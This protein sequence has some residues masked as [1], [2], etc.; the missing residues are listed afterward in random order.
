MAQNDQRD[1]AVI[2]SHICWGPGHS[3]PP[4]PG[5]PQNPP[6]NS[7]PSLNVAPKREGV[8]VWTGPVAPH[9]HF[10]LPFSTVSVAGASLCNSHFPLPF[11]CQ[12]LHIDSLG[13]VEISQKVSELM[14]THI[15]HTTLFN[16]PS[17]DAL[18]AHLW[19][20]V[21][22]NKAAT[23]PALPTPVAALAPTRPDVQA[24]IT[25][26]AARF[27]GGADS[28]ERFWQVLVQCPEV[29]RSL[30]TRID[31]QH[32]Y[33]PKIPSHGKM[34][35]TQAALVEDLEA[36]D[37]EFFGISPS[38]ASFMDPQQRLLLEETWH[39]LEHAG[40]PPSSLSGSA[41]SVLVGVSVSEYHLVHSDASSPTAVSG[42][43]LNMTAGRVAYHFNL[44]GATSAI[45]TAC[46]SSLFALHMAAQQL[47]HQGPMA[48]VAG[49]NAILSPQVF[50]RLCS[51]RA[52]SPRGICAAFDASAD[53]YGRC[54]GCAVLVLEAAAAAAEAARAPL[55]VVRGG[56]VVSDG[57]SNGVSAPNGLAQRRVMQEA[58]G[59]AELAK[60]DV[61][62][63]EAH[64]TG[65]PLGDP[66][67]L[68]AVAAAYGRGRAGAPLVIGT[69]KS[70]LGHAESAVGAAAVMKVVLSLTHSFVPRLKHFQAL[71]PKA[72]GLEAAH[73]RLPLGDGL[74]WP[75]EQAMRRA[76][77]SSF[78]FSGTNVHMLFEE[79]GAEGG[80]AALPPAPPSALDGAWPLCLS[81]ATPAALAQ[82]VQRYAVL[83]P[84]L[85]AAQLPALC[86]AAL[87]C[88]QSHA[89]RAVVEAAD[90]EAMAVQ[91]RAVGQ[92]GAFHRGPGDAEWGLVLGAGVDL[93]RAAAGRA[94]A[95]PAFRTALA[96]CGAALA[97]ATGLDLHRVL[98]GPE[99][100]LPPAHRLLAGLALEY[101]YAALLLAHGARPHVLLAYGAGQYVAGA[102]AGALPLPAALQLAAAH[103]GAMHAGPAPAVGLVPAEENVAGGGTGL[104]VYPAAQGQRVA[105]GTALPPG[106]VPLPPAEA[107]PYLPIASAALRA[108]MEAVAVR[109]PGP[110]PPPHI[111]IVLCGPGHVLSSAEPPPGP[112]H[113]AAGPSQALDVPAAAGALARTGALVYA[114]GAAVPPYLRAVPEAKA[115]HVG[116]DE[117]PMRGLVARCFA[118]GVAVGAEWLE[119]EGAPPAG[120]GGRALPAYPFVRTRHTLRPGAGPKG[121]ATPHAQDSPGPRASSPQ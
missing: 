71:N 47:L 7:A 20:D 30:G 65:T 70:C 121:S 120:A 111:P 101:A 48:L 16:Y 103:C 104:R 57:R 43:A 39:A 113:W 1:E 89:H 116:P 67:E 96:D 115:V 68:E 119:G 24:V 90:P 78:G 108:E 33:S 85:E 27:P 21:L 6:T 93:P 112:G 18:L 40:I 79:A 95:A 69:V 11:S 49:V 81:A 84:G 25:G 31:L 41:T 9:V 46:S 107:L 29:R 5:R 19:H 98:A 26:M 14:G 91:L 117:P 44:H 62:Y 22:G 114:P 99:A 66:I 58:L 42:A 13:I 87:R 106:A 61:G 3:P 28:P 92:T 102:I 38:T 55:A 83:V 77:V 75:R 32:Y 97:H 36:F 118:R 53:G 50:V 86:A 4:P 76:G 80:G 63:Q 82:T 109:L 110:P 12:D 94:F 17:L 34:Y 52:L 59:R 10:P 73:L 56:A 51:V 74:P 64:G 37:A 72:P 60:E 35:C 15:P 23:L 8:G 105:V 2:L 45:D 88:R 54:E 100:P